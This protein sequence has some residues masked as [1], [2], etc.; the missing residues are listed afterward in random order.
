MFALPSCWAGTHRT[1]HSTCAP[2]AR[3]EF[4]PDPSVLLSTLIVGM[5]A[6]AELGRGGGGRSTKSQGVFSKALQ[7]RNVA[8]LLGAIGHWL[9]LLGTW[10]FSFVGCLAFVASICQ[11]C[12]S[13]YTCF[14]PVRDIVYGLVV[15]GCRS[16]RQPSQLRMVMLP[17]RRRCQARIRPCLG[18]CQC[19]R[20]TVLV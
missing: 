20:C 4:S 10:S 9:L 18:R 15:S 13:Q 5:E 8:L 3:G 1:S 14:I 17:L 16:L 7:N 11:R 19:F 12:S 6:P 2:A